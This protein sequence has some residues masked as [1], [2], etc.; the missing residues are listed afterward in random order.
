M[1]RA[2]VKGFITSD[3]SDEMIEE[4]MDSVESEQEDADYDSDD[5]VKDP[6]YF[7]HECESQLNAAITDMQQGESSHAFIPDIDLS[8]IDFDAIDIIP[9]SAPSS[10]IGNLVSLHSLSTEDIQA[11]PIVLSEE[12]QPSTSA[13]AAAAA[14][15]PI[16]LAK[17][18]PFKPKRARSPLPSIEDTGPTFTPNDGGLIGNGE[19]ILKLFE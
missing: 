14:E 6:D 1:S 11:M 2:H 17:S 15:A 10:R 18:T 3:M 8:A 5:S 9:P 13:A 12:A 16:K 4:M 19:F 7:P